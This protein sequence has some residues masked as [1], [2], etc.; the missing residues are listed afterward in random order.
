MR[1]ILASKQTH[2]DLITVHDLALT[3]TEYSSMY[4]RNEEIWKNSLEMQKADYTREDG[5]I[6]YAWIAR[7][8]PQLSEHL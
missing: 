2:G 4:Q 6:G 5:I 7:Y 1:E 8:T 3:H